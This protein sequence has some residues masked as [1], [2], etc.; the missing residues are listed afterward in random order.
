MAQENAKK[1]LEKV[2]ADETLRDRI[3]GKAPEEIVEIAAE[4]GFDVTA[5]DLKNAAESFRKE[6]AGT[7]SAAAEKIRE[8]DVDEMDKAAGGYFFHPQ[9]CSS[10]FD[11]GD[12]CWFDDY[13][14][15]MWNLYALKD[16]NSIARCERTVKSTDW[17]RYDE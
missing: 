6:N 13:C 3:G 2:W 16:D 5:E 14:S 11:D 1:F 17:H 15:Q 9:V 7:N 4:Q 12:T 10:S 8:L